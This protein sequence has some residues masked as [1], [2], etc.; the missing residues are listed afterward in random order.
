MSADDGVRLDSAKTWIEYGD[1]FR[2]FG[3]AFL[4]V[5]SGIT[6]FVGG[7]IIALGETAVN[8][9]A[10]I[11]DAFAQGGGDFIAAFTSAPANFI[12]SSF[13]SAAAEL[14]SAPWNELGPFLPLLAAIIG[15]GVVAVVTW[16]LDRRDSDVPGTGI[17]IPIIGNDEDGDFTDEQ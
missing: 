9:Y 8:F 15:I 4:A 13:N 6:A 11:I 7:S 10:T 5:G 14:Q 3:Q 17:D 2:N 16:Y 1:S 12:G